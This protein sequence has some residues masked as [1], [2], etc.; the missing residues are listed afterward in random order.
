MYYP[1]VYLTSGVERTILEMCRRSRHEYSIFTNHYEPQNTYPEFR[2]LHVVTLPYLPVRRQI[3]PVM[4]AAARIAAQTLPLRDYRVLLVHCDGLGNLILNRSR[5]IPAVC[6]CHTPLRAVYDPLYRARSVQRCSRPGELLYDGFA[7]AFSRVDRIMFRRYRH[8]VFNSRET[9]SRAETGGLLKDMHGRYEILHPGVDWALHEPSWSYKPYFLVAGR[10]MWTKNVELAIEAF[11]RFKTGSPGHEEF[12]LVIAGRVDKKSEPYI[13]G[14][15]QM[16][17]GRADVQFVVSPTDEDL[18]RLYS[19]CYCLLYPPFNEDWGMVPL[20]ANAFGKPVIACDRG[21]PTES[22]IHGE[23]GLLVPSDPR[24]FTAAMSYL[25]DHPSLTRA[26]GMKARAASL[27]Y[28][29]AV[30]VRRFDAILDAA[31]DPSSDRQESLEP[32]EEPAAM[33]AL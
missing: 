8:V 28:D 19:E 15:Q 26:M 30:F 11:L 23:T 29:W 2:H 12:R 17:M 1:W 10:I 20:E 31:V 5:R 32:D 27:A 9:L 22:Q 3:I 18:R 7:A 25:A 4:L 24:E 6:M 33:S 14:L 13:E 21:G 16:V